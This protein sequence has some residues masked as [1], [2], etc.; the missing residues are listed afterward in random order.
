MLL[1]PSK[2]PNISL[3]FYFDATSP[4]YAFWATQMLPAAIP[5]RQEVKIM[6]LIEMNS[7]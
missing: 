4:I 3:I 5:Q 1:T 6:T 7:F 2:I